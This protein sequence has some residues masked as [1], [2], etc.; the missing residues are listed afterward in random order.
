MLLET[1]PDS[2]IA[3]INGPDSRHDQ[4]LCGKPDKGMDIGITRIAVDCPH[5]GIIWESMRNAAEQVLGQV[6][7]DN[8]A[9]A[10]ELRREANELQRAAVDL[11]DAAQQ[12]DWDVISPT[13]GTDTAD[14]FCM[15][16]PRGLCKGWD[17]RKI[18]GF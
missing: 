4:T 16:S 18:R 14:V 5:C 9:K 10:E 6:I 11:I 17:P 8:L 12:E 3:H 1:T 2:V 13:I 7:R 15:V